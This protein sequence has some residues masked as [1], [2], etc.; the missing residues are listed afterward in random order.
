MDKVKIIEVKQRVFASN[1]ERAE[2][3]RKELKARGI[4]LL[5]LMS[6]PGSEKTYLKT[7]NEIIIREIETV[8]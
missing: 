5:N 3:L 7:G 1:D 4:L 6:S 8:E 2:L